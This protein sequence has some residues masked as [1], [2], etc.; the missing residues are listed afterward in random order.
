M[1]SCP[2]LGC[3]RIDSRIS[4]WRRQA[5]NALNY[6]AP[7][8]SRGCVPCLS[9]LDLVVR[10]AKR[11]NLPYTNDM[12]SIKVSIQTAR[13]HW[14]EQ[15]CQYSTDSDDF[16]ALSVWFFSKESPLAQQLSAR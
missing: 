13:E 2:S 4:S 16:E 10:Q 5:E 9:A 3:K 11:N 14:I 8:K 12:D 15:V 7:C 1:R 6:D